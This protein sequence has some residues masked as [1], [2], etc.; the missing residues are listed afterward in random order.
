MFRPLAAATAAPDQS[1][2][3]SAGSISLRRTS[4][5]DGV[6]HDRLWHQECIGAI[7]GGDGQDGIF[8]VQVAGAPGAFGPVDRALAGEAVDIDHPEPD[9]T[10]V[11]ELVYRPFHV[12]ELR[13]VQHARRV[14]DVAGQPERWCAARGGRQQD[15]G[16][17]D[18]ED[19]AEQA[20]NAHDRQ[21]SAIAGPGHPVR[22][23][24]P[25]R[26]CVG[27]HS[28]WSAIRP[29]RRVRPAAAGGRTAEGCRPARHRL[30]TSHRFRPGPGAGAALRRAAST[31]RQDPGRRATPERHP[32]HAADAFVGGG[33]DRPRHGDRA[34]LRP[35]SCRH[36]RAGT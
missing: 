24:T 15:P 1:S 34:G 2:P 25:G 32:A 33:P 14:G 21:C 3:R 29:I 27:G 10:F 4:L 20:G 23:K 6:A 16:G 17:Q 12:A 30:R 35:R 7:R 18:R 13:T 28:S 5:D 11:V 36:G 9:L 8:V 26:L 19:Q 31:G 22:A